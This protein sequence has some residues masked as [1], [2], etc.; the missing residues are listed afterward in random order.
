MIGSDTFTLEPCN[1]TLNIFQDFVFTDFKQLRT[2]MFTHARQVSSLMLL[3][4][5]YETSSA[6]PVQLHLTSR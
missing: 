5:F 2:A 3:K 6:M 4:T 1:F